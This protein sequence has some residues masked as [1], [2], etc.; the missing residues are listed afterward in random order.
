M[1]AAWTA[2]TTSSTPT[3]CDII[4]AGFRLM[5]TWRATP[6]EVCTCPTPGTFWKRLTMIWSVIVVSSRSVLVG[7]VTASCTTGCAL[8]K[9]PRMMSG[10][11]ASRGKSGR[12]S[13]I[14][15]RTSCTPRDMSVSRRNSM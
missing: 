6:P 3:P 4:C 11:F 15:S 10:S 12:T 2:R 9:S 1:F 8:S 14:L 5:S 7:E 13:A